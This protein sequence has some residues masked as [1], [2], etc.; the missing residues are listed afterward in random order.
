MNLFINM[1][2]P[3]ATR[4]NFEFIPAPLPTKIERRGEE[5]DQVRMV[6]RA[7]HAWMYD[8]SWLTDN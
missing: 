4:I 8:S 3:V 5:F 2:L 6:R 1:P 7:I